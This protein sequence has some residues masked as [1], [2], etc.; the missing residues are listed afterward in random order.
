MVV[1]PLPFGPMMEKMV[2]CSTEKLTSL[3][4]RIPPKL[5]LKF[6]TEKWAMLTPCF[7]E[8]AL[9]FLPFSPL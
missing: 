6:S 2:F 3:T 1:F 9:F 8:D 4:A 5:M 7:Y